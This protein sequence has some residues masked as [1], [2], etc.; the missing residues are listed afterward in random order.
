[1]LIKKKKKTGCSS[2]FLVFFGIPFALVG[3]FLGVKSVRNFSDS[4]EMKNWQQV[5]AEIINVELITSTSDDTTTHS[6]NVVYQ[7]Q[8]SGNK[9]KGTR[10]NISGGGESGSYYPTLYKKVKSH[11]SSGET[12]R[13][14]VNPNNPSESILNKNL[15]V[16]DFIIFPAISILFGGVGIGLFIFGIISVKQTKLYIN[17]QEQNPD[18]PWLHKPEWTAGKI[19]S[20]NKKSTY[21]AL[22]FAL[23]WN[24]ISWPIAISFIPEILKEKN[25]VFLFVFLFP[26]V[27]L[28]LIIWTVVLFTRWK[29][30]GESVFT[31]NSNPGVVGGALKE[32]IVTK[33][34]V[35]PEDGFKVELN[36]VN[37]YSSGTGKNRST[38]E[39]VLWQD[40]YLIKHEVFEDDITQSAIPVLFKIPF[41]LR[42]TNE[43]NLRDA[44]IWRL[45]ISADVPGVDYKAIFEI[46][47]FKTEESKENL[48]IDSSSLNKYLGKTTG[49]SLL[50]SSGI[51]SEKLMN[52]GVK[53]I[54]PTA[55]KKAI[56]LFLF[57]LVWGAIV[58]CLWIIESPPMII[59]VI[60]TA[61]LPLIIYGFL[62]RLLYKSEVSVSNGSISIMNGWMGICSEHNFSPSDIEEIKLEDATQSDKRIF[63]SIILITNSGKKITI[64]RRIDDRLQARH[65]IDEIKK[66]CS[67]L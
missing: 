2:Y 41:D 38:A 13:C 9:Y 63:S 48:E 6:I 1:M 53:F 25:Y 42:E 46:P 18:K 37:R 61:I 43:E 10:V 58:V 35:K 14:F 67:E 52:G 55:G 31:M 29:K 51:I 12:Y 8:V 40:E 11:K 60:F 5:P 20:S 26:L 49:D 27:G 34:N 17:L 57:S 19:K 50:K 21:F 16:V 54:F 23:F 22:F 44:I 32:I 47:V 45:K 33:V 15:R 3:I 65:I 39:R 30:Y 24:L 64:A 4:Y 36:C 28:G 7:Y 56:P 59:K 62:D 66:T